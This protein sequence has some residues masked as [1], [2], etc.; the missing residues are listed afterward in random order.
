MA[1]LRV[2]LEKRRGRKRYNLR[3]VDYSG[4]EHRE[5]IGTKHTL[6]REAETIRSQ[7]EAE[8]NR[9]E[10][11]AAPP[12]KITLAEAMRMDRELHADLRELQ[13]LMRHRQQ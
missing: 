1:G 13:A 7:R 6:R 3:W 12:P 9:G 4:G 8:I 10:L 2:Y 5:S 11:P